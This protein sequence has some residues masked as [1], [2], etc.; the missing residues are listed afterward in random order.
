M[1]QV[2]V[3]RQRLV[4]PIRCPLPGDTW[5]LGS[6]EIEVQVGPRGRVLSCAL[7][8][9]PARMEVLVKLPKLVAHHGYPVDPAVLAR[10]AVDHALVLSFVAK[11]EVLAKFPPTLPDVEALQRALAAMPSILDLGRYQLDGVSVLEG[12]QLAV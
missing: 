10:Q 7:R 2:H 1:S 8:V 6:A 11:P 3:L 9:F 4:Q 12:V 5:V